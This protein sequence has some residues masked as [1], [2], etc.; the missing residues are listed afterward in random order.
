MGFLINLSKSELTPSR[1]IQHLGV[2][3][4]T[5][6]SHLFLTQER[7]IKTRSLLTPVIGKSHSHLMD[8]AKLMGVLVA[9]IDAVQWIRLHL[10]QFHWFLKP[11][12]L[13]ITHSSNLTLQVPFKV[14]NS[15]KWWTVNSN[16]S[17]GKQ[18]LVERE[19][20]LITDA[21]LLGWG[22]V[23]R[24]NPVQGKW[25]AT[26][27]ILPINRLELRALR[28]ALQH[29]TEGLKHVLVRTDNISAK[30]HINKQEGSRSLG[31]HKEFLK[32]FSWAEKHILSI[33]AEHIKVV[34]NVEADWLSREY[35]DPGEWSLK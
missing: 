15:L 30:A 19:E 13:H 1:T 34:D 12:Q 24:G 35:M 5:Q 18:Y 11:Y 22:A 3:I 29:F 21:S 32:L 10:R 20:H 26:D 14:R 7:R 33:R 6:S 8:L 28:L 16:L 27:S 31:L 23:W 4:D 2:I 9:S 17:S 25:S